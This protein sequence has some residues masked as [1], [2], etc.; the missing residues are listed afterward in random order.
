LAL[1][2]LQQ[3]TL[4]TAPALA[5]ATQP[6]LETLALDGVRVLRSLDPPPSTGTADGNLLSVERVAQTLL[7]ESA[8]A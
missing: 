3:R 1:P 5:S 4:T 2:A 8:C 7:E 6:T